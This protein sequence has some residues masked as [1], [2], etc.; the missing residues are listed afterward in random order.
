MDDE[1]LSIPIFTQ[2]Y[3]DH[4][5]TEV[6]SNRRLRHIDLIFEAMTNTL[7]K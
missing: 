2:L 1:L 5:F 3:D 6:S 7:Q 4:R